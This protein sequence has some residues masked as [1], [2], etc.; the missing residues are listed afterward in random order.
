[1]GTTV[2]G[3]KLNRP[4][5]RRNMYIILSVLILL[6]VSLFAWSYVSKTNVLKTVSDKL[7]LG[8]IVP[9]FQANIYGP[10]GDPLNKPMAVAVV[11]K[12]IYITDTNNKKEKR[13][14]K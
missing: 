6:E 12:Q 7:P 8:A 4:M 2:V 10:L 3:T 1:M 5:R 13:Y 9:T 14:S 11:N